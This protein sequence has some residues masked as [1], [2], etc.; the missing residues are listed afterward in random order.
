MLYRY[1]MM[2]RFI[3]HCKLQVLNN[4]NYLT[5]LT[6]IKSPCKGIEC[7]VSKAFSRRQSLPLVFEL[8]FPRTTSPLQIHHIRIHHGENP[9]LSHDSGLSGRHVSCPRT[10]LAMSLISSRS[11]IVELETLSHASSFHCE[12]VYPRAR[13]AA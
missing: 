1:K 10:F 9:M 5:V 6:C 4:Y 12:E 11:A 3:V 7:K 2:F 8:F 13:A